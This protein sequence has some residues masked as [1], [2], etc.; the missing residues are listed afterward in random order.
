[1]PH[2]VARADIAGAALQSLS[3]A[4]RLSPGPGSY[5]AAT[6]GRSSR[7]RQPGEAQRFQLEAAYLT[8]DRQ[9]R[10]RRHPGG[11]ACAGRSRRPGSHPDRA[12]HAR[13]SCS[14]QQAWARSPARR[15]GAGGRARPGEQRCRRCKSSWRSSAICSPALAGRFRADEGGADSTSPRC[16]CR[17][18]L[19][20]SLPVQPRRAAARHPRSPRQTCMPPAPRSASPSPTGCRKITLTAT[21]GCSRDQVRPAV[22]PRQRLLD[23]G[24]G[25]AQPI[26]TA[27][28]C[29]TA[30]AQPKPPTTRRRRSTRTVL[31]R[32]RTSPIRC[33]PFDPTPRR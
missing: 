4:A 33:A 30:S 20:V 32:S 13:Q 31:T 18:D 19:P 25:V 8:L 5:S 14:R 10:R 29:C 16:S 11:V 9:R 1:M 7:C 22:R 28:R 21:G 2:A 27:A 3:D 17:S 24:A 26:S 15:R 23:V 6:R 12:R